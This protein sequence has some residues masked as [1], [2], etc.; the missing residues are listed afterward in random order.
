MEI[1][2]NLHKP[3]CEL[4]ILKLICF[5][6]FAQFRPTLSD[7]RHRESVGAAG[8]AESPPRAVSSKPPV[9]TQSHRLD[10]CWVSYALVAS[11]VWRLITIAVNVPQKDTSSSFFLSNFVIYYSELLKCFL[12]QPGSV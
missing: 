1:K 9:V 8:E 3:V 6:K 12:K 4:F 11:R 7:R 2:K 10:F 5:L